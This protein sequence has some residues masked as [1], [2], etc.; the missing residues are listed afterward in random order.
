MKGTANLRAVLLFRYIINEISFKIT[1]RLRF[2][3]LVQSI[4]LIKKSKLLFDNVLD[5]SLKKLFLRTSAIAEVV[6]TQI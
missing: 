3:N 5:N 4:Y 2:L 6:L 1:Y